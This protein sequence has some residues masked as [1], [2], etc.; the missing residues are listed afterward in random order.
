MLKDI[1]KIVLGK[2]TADLTS[3][4]K[5]VLSKQSPWRFNSSIGAIRISPC[6]G[7]N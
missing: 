6:I 4:E 3:A 5:K 1:E 7:M 2:Q